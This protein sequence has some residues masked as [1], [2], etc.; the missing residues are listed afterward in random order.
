MDSF[1]DCPLLI[2]LP[3]RLHEED[4][5]EDCLNS[6]H[7]DLDRLRFFMVSSKYIFLQTVELVL[8]PSYPFYAIHRCPPGLC[9]STILQNEQ[10]ML[11]S[12]T[13]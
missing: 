9:P 8:D 10:V 13:F 3:F 11:I 4:V 5:F 7:K 1:H 2:C 6:S 12:L